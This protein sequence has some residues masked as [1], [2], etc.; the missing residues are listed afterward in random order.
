MG[1]MSRRSFSAEDIL[2]MMS[3]NCGARYYKKDYD[4]PKYQNPD[5]CAKC[6]G[7]CCKRCGC[8][9]S[10]DDFSV[11]NFEALVNEIEKGYITIE[12]I[13]LDQFYMEGFAWVMRM[14][15]KNG[16][17]VERRMIRPNSE[18]IM[19]TERGCAFGYEHR[20]TGGRLL[21]PC[22]HGECESDYSTEKAIREWLNYQRL[23]RQLVEHFESALNT[24]G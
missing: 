15:N 2:E 4:N 23:L 14:R 17:I 16:P 24:A 11:L 10:P 13:D 21:I 8:F 22:E 12:L 7:K 9:F 18:C 3:T 20:P 19:L 1:T 5:M 6:G